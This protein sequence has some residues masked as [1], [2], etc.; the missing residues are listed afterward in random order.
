MKITIVNFEKQYLKDMG[1]LF[2]EVYDEPGFEWDQETAEKCLWENVERSPEFCL[3]AVNEQ[4]ECVGGVFGKV[5][6]Y[7][8]GESL[9]VDTLQVEKKYRGMGVAKKLMAEVV[10]RARER[11]LVGINFMA[12][13][14]QEFPRKWY[15]ELGFLPSNWVEY[16]ASLDEIKI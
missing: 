6:P 7:Y 13:A 4:G 12:D 1:R 2:R 5:H 14:R 15:E 11:K 9:F 10:K 3:V 8:K 16:E